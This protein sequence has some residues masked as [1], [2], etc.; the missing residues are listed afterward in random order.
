MDGVLLIRMTVVYSTVLSSLHVARTFR[1][2]LDST[3]ALLGATCVY[4][5]S[6]NLLHHLQYKI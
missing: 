3:V 2:L 1:P 5:A 6:L 4:L